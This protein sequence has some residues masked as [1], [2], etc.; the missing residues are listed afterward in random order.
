MGAAIHKAKR[1]IPPG[2]EIRNPDVSAD[3]KCG[4]IFLELRDGSVSD[5]SIGNMWDSLGK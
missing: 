2:A 4:E 3:P 1:N 5:D